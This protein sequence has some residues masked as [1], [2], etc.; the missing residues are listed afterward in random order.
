MNAGP[1]NL[2][3]LGNNNL[4]DTSQYRKSTLLGARKTAQPVKADDLLNLVNRV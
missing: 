1:T 4:I 3:G 2:P